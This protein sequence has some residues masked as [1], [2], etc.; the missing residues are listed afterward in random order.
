MPVTATWRSGYAAVCKAT[1]FCCLV[2]DHSDKTAN[3]DPFP[4]NGLAAASEW[5]GLQASGCASAPFTR[6]RGV[7]SPPDHDLGRP[8]GPQKATA[9]RRAKISGLPPSPSGRLSRRGISFDNLDVVIGHSDRMVDRGDQ[10]YAAIESPKPGPA[11]PAFV[12]ASV[13]P[14]AA[15]SP[16]NLLMCVGVSSS[17]GMGGGQ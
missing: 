3:F 5:F 7:V 10:P 2:N 1:C 8:G 13:S 17:R 14:L 6:P 12:S 16:L 4:I 11:G 15:S 9:A